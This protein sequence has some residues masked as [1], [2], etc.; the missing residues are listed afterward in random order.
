MTNPHASCHALVAADHLGRD[1]EMTRGSDHSSMRA[2]I[3]CKWPKRKAPLSSRRGMV[4][5]HRQSGR[6]AERP[7]GKRFCCPFYQRAGKALHSTSLRSP[8]VAT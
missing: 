8:S 4:R 6:Q 3:T 2:T 1:P 5:R 7:G